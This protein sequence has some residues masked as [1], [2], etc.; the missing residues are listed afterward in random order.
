[1]LVLSGVTARKDIALYPY[2]PAYVLAGIGSI[3][4]PS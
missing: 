1:V 2:R 3:P 4:P